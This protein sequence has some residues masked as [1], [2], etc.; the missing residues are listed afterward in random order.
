MALD[1]IQLAVC[2]YQASLGVGDGGKAHG[3]FVLLYH[4]HRMLP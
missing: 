3:V 4:V 2:G 1:E